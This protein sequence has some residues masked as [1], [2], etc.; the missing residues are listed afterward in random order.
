MS[1][2][3]RAGDVGDGLLFEGT[4]PS[5]RLDVRPRPASG[6]PLFGADAAHVTRRHGSFRVFVT[7]AGVDPAV[8]GDLVVLVRDDVRDGE[9]VLCRVASACVTST[10]LAS[11]ECD[12][13]QQLDA[14]LAAI[15]AADRGV[16]LY[17]THHEGRGHGLLTKVR[18]L[19]HKNRGLD[20]FAAVEALGL[21]PDVRS[22]D[23]V[24]P[25]LDALGVRSI[26]LLGSNPAKRDAL[27][28]VGVKVA[29][30][31]ALRVMPPVR[32]Q[33]SMRAKQQRGHQVVG[34]YADDPS[35]PYP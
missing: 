13:S 31:R 25:I 26:V 2:G 3:G 15:D 32:A 18:A 7:V 4:Y 14:A 20:T 11:A 30:T 10:A 21:A 6:S 22:Y 24:P 29:Q 23:A 27:S 12:C 8:P 5:R 17:L 34:A 1:D 35:V 16:L 28:A 9:R 19:A 33:R